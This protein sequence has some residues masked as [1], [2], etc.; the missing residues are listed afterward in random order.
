M[1]LEKDQEIIGSV[2]DWSIYSG[3]KNPTLFKPS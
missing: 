1:R 3:A 2:H